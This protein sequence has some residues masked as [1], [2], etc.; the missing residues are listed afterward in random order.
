MKSQEIAAAIHYALSKEHR[1]I[2]QQV[3]SPY[4]EGYAAEKI[5][6]KIIEVV[7]KGRI[8]LKKKF[9]DL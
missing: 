7:T 6:E 9:Y 5:V 4:G 3:I 8:D 2:C 1:E